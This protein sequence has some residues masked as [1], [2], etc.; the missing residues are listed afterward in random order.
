MANI[1]HVFHPSPIGSSR[2]VHSSRLFTDPAVISAFNVCL[3]MSWG[4][5]YF[6][7]GEHTQLNGS[8]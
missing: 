4:G 3:A 1:I 8:I 7:E 5:L 6:K 2:A